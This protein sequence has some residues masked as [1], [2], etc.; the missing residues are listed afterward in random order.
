MRTTDMI[1]IGEL[2]ATELAGGSLGISFYF[3]LYLFGLGVAVAVAPMAAQ[4]IGARQFKIVR[5]SVR[6]GFWVA[7]LIGILVHLLL[8]QA[9]PILFAFGQTAH[10]VALAQAYLDGVAW[11]I[12][13]SLWIVVLRSFAVAH[14]RTR[15]VFLVTLAGALLHVLG[16]YA[17]IFGH[18]G[19]PALGVAGAGI[20]N[21]LVQ[22]LM[23]L[24]LL[25]HAQVDRRFRR[26]M[27]LVRFWRT[28]WPRFFE[29]L[30][31]GLPIGLTILAESGFFA[32]ALFV[33]GLI[34]TLELAAHAIAIQ[35]VAIAFM[36]PLGIA[37]AATVRVGLA[38]GAG[39]KEGV[40][41]AGW[42]AIAL[43]AGFS[44]VPALVF[45]FLPK[46]VVSAYLDLDVS[47][48]LRVAGIAVTFLA[49]AAVFQLFDGIQIIAAAALRGLKDT[50]MPLVIALIGYWPLGFGVCLLLAFPLGLSGEGIWLG[51]A[52]GLLVVASLLI[53]RFHR[54]ERF[55]SGPTEL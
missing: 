15:M 12:V 49:I 27:L 31:I 55:W 40:G 5:R 35:C 2:G 11:G 47:E 23:F 39:D 3:P 36:V 8:S 45:W 43:G 25:G 48:N 33:M 14:S 38:A 50:R 32:A 29:V 37:Q 9:T 44:I 52:L 42:T 41:R 18:F 21:S 7:A 24:A 16:A 30:R 26:Y 22:W 6:Q 53:W 46:T 34:G 1:L 4:A 28:D 19:L 54:R 13:P 10:T 51:F 17:L 20:S